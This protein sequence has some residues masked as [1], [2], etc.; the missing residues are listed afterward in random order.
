M[1]KRNYGY[2]FNSG[3]AWLIRGSET[4]LTQV[5]ENGVH[6]DVRKSGP[7]KASMRVTIVMEVQNG[8]FQ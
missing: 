6:T 2:M 3:L 4:N 8:V 7:Y 1:K 5:S